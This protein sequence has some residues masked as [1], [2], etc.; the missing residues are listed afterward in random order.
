[1]DINAA[2]QAHST[3]KLRLNRFADG[4][5]QESLDE[6]TI[7]KDNVCDLGKWLHGEGK[8]TLASH[9]S[10]NDLI[11]EHAEFH[12]QASNIVKLCKSAQTAKAKQI[13]ADPNSD[14]NKATIKV[15]GILMKLK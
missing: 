5:S 8:K 6:N 13:L 2:I 4:G 7:G 11:K 15:V 10:Y 9:P 14:Y 3:W 12:R 1:M